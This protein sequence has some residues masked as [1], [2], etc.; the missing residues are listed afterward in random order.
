LDAIQ[1]FLNI[2]KPD[3]TGFKR[4]YPRG[5]L[6]NFFNGIG[7]EIQSGFQFQ[8]VIISYLHDISGKL[9]Y[10]SILHI[11]IRLKIC[12]PAAPKSI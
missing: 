4:D 1:T 9:I 6:I 3:F 11:K 8:S 2:L 12:I 5:G 10:G 7:N